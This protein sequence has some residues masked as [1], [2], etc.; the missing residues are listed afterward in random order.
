MIILRKEK[1]L[2]ALE[3]S[4]ITNPSLTLM[5]K[6]RNT[7]RMLLIVLANYNLRRLRR[8]THALISLKAK[9][10]RFTITSS[11]AKSQFPLQ[12]INLSTVKPTRVKRRQPS[13]AHHTQPLSPLS[14][15]SESTRLCT[16]RNILLN[17]HLARPSVRSTV[18]QE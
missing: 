11:L 14:N 17:P 12:S 8:M 2:L 5:K 4:M 18:A 1:K 6:Q 3:L 16:K 7:C 15:P 9:L 10:L 13:I